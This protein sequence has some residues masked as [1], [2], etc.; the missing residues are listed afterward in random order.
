MSKKK[1]LQIKDSQVKKES[2][3]AHITLAAIEQ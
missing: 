3:M 2:P 1:Q